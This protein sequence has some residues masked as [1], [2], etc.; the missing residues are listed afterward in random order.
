MDSTGWRKA[1]LEGRGG[2]EARPGATAASIGSQEALRN[3][4]RPRPMRCGGLLALG[5][6]PRPN[7]SNAAVISGKEGG[8]E[9]MLVL[10]RLAVKESTVVSLFPT[11]GG[12]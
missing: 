3:R 9:E 5:C 7:P 1:S 2:K 11:D 12:P 4:P 10:A 8:G 6:L